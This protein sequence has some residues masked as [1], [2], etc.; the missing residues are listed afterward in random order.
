[1][2]TVGGIIRL[3]FTVPAGIKVFDSL[4]VSY[5]VFAVDSGKNYSFTFRTEVINDIKAICK[6]TGDTCDLSEITGDFTDTLTVGTP[7]I[8][9]SNLNTYATCNN[10]FGEVVHIDYDLTNYNKPTRSGVNIYANL[11]WDANNNNQLDMVIDQK[12]RNI[13]N[14]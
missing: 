1:M 6:T 8:R 12:N 9:L 13:C 7:D 10:P 5:R 4:K 14:C 11:W 2:D 3:T